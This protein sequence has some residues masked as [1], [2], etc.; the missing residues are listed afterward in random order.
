MHGDHGNVVLRVIK[1]RV[2]MPL[3]KFN[4][5][6]ND[7]FFLDHDDR[8]I[9]AGDLMLVDVGGDIRIARALD[10]YAETAQGREDIYEVIGKIT[11]L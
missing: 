11:V 5:N 2:L 1:C 4:L 6:A 8:K 3:P 7:I 9:T 10:G